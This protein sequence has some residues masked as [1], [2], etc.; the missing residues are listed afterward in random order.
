MRCTCHD[1]LLAP[2]IGSASPRVRVMVIFFQYV[3][4]SSVQLPE[5]Y[6]MTI[7]GSAKD[8]AVVEEILVLLTL[9][10]I[11]ILSRVVSPYDMHMP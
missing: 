10:E 3:L 1:S 7:A 6:R 4:L 8:S 5:T 9:T 11:G 2:R